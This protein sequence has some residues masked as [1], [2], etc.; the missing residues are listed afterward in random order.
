MVRHI[1]DGME[2][3]LMF[4]EPEQ[5]IIKHG[6]NKTDFMYV[7]VA[8]QF[9]VSVRDQSKEEEE[10]MVCRNLTVGDYFGEVA[11]FFDSNRSASV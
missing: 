1:V 11:L 6:S 5:K 3:N 7:V 10:D 4:V 9:K 2:P 8:G